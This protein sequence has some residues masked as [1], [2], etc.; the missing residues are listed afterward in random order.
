MIYRFFCGIRLRGT[1]TYGGPVL[2]R[3][4]RSCRTLKRPRNKSPTAYHFYRKPVSR[5]DSQA[6]LWHTIKGTFTCGNTQQ[7]GGRNVD[8]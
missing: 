1:F 4:D 2:A 5:Y 8:S 6:F 7:F 3:L